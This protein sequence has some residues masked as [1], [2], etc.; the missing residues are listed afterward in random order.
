MRYLLVGVWNTLF[1]YGCYALLTYLLTG[2]LPHAY[3]AAAV[4]STGIN[5]TVSYLG[6]KVFVFRT[7]G[8]YLQ[9]YLRCYV[10]YGTSTLVNLAL[11]P[12]LV[13]VL[14]RSLRR[15]EHAPYIAGAILIAGTVVVSFVGHKRYSFATKSLPTAITEPDRNVAQDRIKRLQS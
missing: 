3:M 14:N 15:P 10:V 1:G 4:L 2:V 5:I 6:Y 13:A 7:K 8:N 11:L 12:V 9:E